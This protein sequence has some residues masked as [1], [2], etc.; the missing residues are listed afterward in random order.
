MDLPQLALRFF[1]SM[2]LSRSSAV[3]SWD[4][5]RLQPPIAMIAMASRTKTRILPMPWLLLRGVAARFDGAA[6]GLVAH[7]RL[8]LGGCALLLILALLEIALLALH[9]HLGLAPGYFLLLARALLLV[10]ALAVRGELHVADLRLLRVGAGLVGAAQG[11][12]IGAFARGLLAVGEIHARLVGF[13]RRIDDGFLELG[14]LGRRLLLVGEA[15]LLEAKP[16]PFVG[17]IHVVET[18]AAD[19]Q[20]RGR[21]RHEPTP[22]VRCDG[23]HFLALAVLEPLLVVPVLLGRARKR[24]VS[25]AE[26]ALLG[27]LLGFRKAGFREGAHLALVCDLG[28]LGRDFVRN[29]QRRVEVLHYCSPKTRWRAAHFYSIPVSIRGQPGRTGALFHP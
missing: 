3:I 16:F 10:L 5:G 13:L 25:L 2:I 14:P 7:S 21:G 24:R 29:A 18:E 11:I 17:A 6:V 4:A 22:A 28:N 12:G 26:E 1:S 15:D 19:Q 23:V 27:T 8:A 9:F 20:D